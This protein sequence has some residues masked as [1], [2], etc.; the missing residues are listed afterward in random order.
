MGLSFRRL[1]Q[2]YSLKFPLAVFASLRFAFFAIM[3]TLIT[4]PEAYKMRIERLS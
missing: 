3:G 1:S 2:R 4:R